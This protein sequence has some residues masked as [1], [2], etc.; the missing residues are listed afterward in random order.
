MVTQDGGRRLLADLGEL[1]R[2]VIRVLFVLA[3]TTAAGL[4][5]AG[6]LLAVLMRPVG[7]L[8]YL[9]PAEAMMTHFRLAFATGVAVTLP[10]TLVNAAAFAGRR[11]P[12]R[13]RLKLYLLLLLGLFLFV[14]GATF[15]FFFVVPTVLAF[16][17][18]FASPKIRPLLGL[19]NYTAFVFGLVIP[20]GLVFQL[21][22][23][24]AAL[25]RVGVLSPAALARQRR[26]A[27]VIIFFLAALLTP[28]DVVS[29]LM[30]AGPLLVLFEVGVL[31][32]KLAWRG[33][34]ARRKSGT[35]AE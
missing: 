24:I 15:A 17:L 33:R 35:A 4:A 2:R 31:L 27:I 5:F 34:A 32:A 7:E 11:L 14:A 1:R 10:F 28:P 19:A 6:R 20:F 29:Q 23:T 18:S 13:T 8:V 9:A 16:F 22:L 30:M 12:R 25:A 26:F 21:P 3:A